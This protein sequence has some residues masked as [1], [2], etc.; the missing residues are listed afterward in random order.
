MIFENGNW[1][2]TYHHKMAADLC[3]S[4]TW[5]GCT[6]AT[7]WL[8]DVYSRSFLSIVQPDQRGGMGKE[9][10][11]Y[12]HTFWCCPKQSL[13]GSC[14]TTH[15]A[16]WLFWCNVTDFWQF[17]KVGFSQIYCTKE[18]H[19]VPGLGV[20]MCVCWTLCPSVD[21]LLDQDTW[22][23]CFGHIFIYYMDFVCTYGIHMG[24]HMVE[25]YVVFRTTNKNYA[26][27]RTCQ[28]FY[29]INCQNL[30]YDLKTQLSGYCTSV[31]WD[32]ALMSI[33]LD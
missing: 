10:R 16:C 26:T 23:S 30:Q 17:V 27:T 3:Y 9:F 7:E 21:P 31:C 22:N 11:L 6:Y 18:Q 29:S 28:D 12:E 5:P 4:T 33:D 1:V 19:K 20:G 15:A 25:R 13:C 14:V 24:Q 2:L 32:I 8:Y